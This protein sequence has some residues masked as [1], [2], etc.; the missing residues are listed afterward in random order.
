VR[1]RFG[2]NRVFFWL[3]GIVPLFGVARLDFVV[4]RLVLVVALGAAGS[5]FGADG[6]G[7]LHLVRFGF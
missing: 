7:G 3:V 1:F 2:E 6:L 5:G 4:I